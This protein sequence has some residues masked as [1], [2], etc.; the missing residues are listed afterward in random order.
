MK[1]L[2][3][4]MCA[5]ALMIG[6]TNCT[7]I[8][9]GHVGIKVSN[10]GTNRGVLDTPVLTGWVF[11]MPGS[12]YVIEYP[13][14]VQTVQWTKAVTEGNPINEEIVFTNN[15]KMTVSVDTS[16]SYQIDPNK[17]PAFYV[18]FKTDDLETFTNGYLH[19][20][21]RDCFNEHGGH[22]SIDDIMGDNA[23]F[24]HEVRSC[25]QDNVASVG[26]GIQQFGLIG[27]PRP[28]DSVMQQIN[29]SAVAA[30]ITIQKQ[31]E[32]AQTQADAAKRVASAEGEAKA[33]IA[34]ANG[35]AEANR[36]VSASINPNILEK[37]RL[38]NQHDAIWRWNG[39][40]PNVVSGGQSMFLFD[41]K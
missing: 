5:F 27:A 2:F 34:R 3:T 12:S 33:N 4:I 16:L 41:T 14:F 39:Q 9:P 17:V 20:V 15:Q 24:L 1:K 13:T 7:R 18:K 23:K 21:A 32:L 6:M 40:T 25:I 22:Y 29:S 31:N 11:Y 10:A 8:G 30:Q 28:P 38:D 35:I 36:I 26:V 37:Q 19:N